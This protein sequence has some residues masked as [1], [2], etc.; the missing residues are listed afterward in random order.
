MEHGGL[1]A[2][3]AR[4]HSEAE[5]TTLAGLHTMLE[6]IRGCI[7]ATELTS[8]G[9]GYL[10]PSPNRTSAYKRV[11]LFLRWMIRKDAVD[12][13]LWQTASPAHCLMPLD[14]HVARL[15]RLLGLTSRKSI[16]SKMVLEVTGALRRLSPEDPVKYDFALSRLG[17]LGA[18]PR[19]PLHEVCTPCDLRRVC[20]HWHTHGDGSGGDITTRRE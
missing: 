1:E 2:L 16:D 20:T 12:L 19:K 3:F 11:H 5:V 18:C 7:S 15:A 8:Y 17:I 14:T 6:G 13:G 4:G 10:L 9:T